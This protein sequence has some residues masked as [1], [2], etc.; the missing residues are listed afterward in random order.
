MHSLD[1][2]LEVGVPKK[3]LVALFR[4][5]GTLERTVSRV[6]SEVFIKAAGP[7]EGLVATFVGTDVLCSGSVSIYAQKRSQRSILFGR[8]FEA[9]FFFDLVVPV[10][11]VAKEPSSSTNSCGDAASLE[12]VPELVELRCWLTASPAP[13]F[14]LF[15]ASYRI[16]DNFRFVEGG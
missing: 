4:V 9:C 1:M 10:G 3:R 15:A 11:C 2:S 5:K 14:V 13:D 7:S 12:L 8:G 16:S 6:G